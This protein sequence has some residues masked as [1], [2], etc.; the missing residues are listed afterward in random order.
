MNKQEMTAKVIDFTSR[1]VI[2]EQERIS[3]D[4]R[5]IK[6]DINEA[7]GF[8]L[9]EMHNLGYAD[10]LMELDTQ[11]RMAYLLEVA[12]AIFSMAEG[13]AHVYSKHLEEITELFKTDGVNEPTDIEGA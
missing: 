2:K 13:H 6:D 8:F 5:I 12:Y 7:F 1:R 10:S 4:T 11:L 9:E 3:T